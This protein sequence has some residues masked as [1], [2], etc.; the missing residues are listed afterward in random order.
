MTQK[1]IGVIYFPLPRAGQLSQGKSV[2]LESAL[3]WT[4]SPSGPAAKVPA[5]RSP[6]R[7]RRSQQWPMAGG[8]R[9]LCPAL[10][11]TQRAR[12]R[13]ASGGIFCRLC[14]EKR[15]SASTLQAAAWPGQ[16]LCSEGGLPRWGTVLV[17]RPPRNENVLLIYTQGVLG[18]QC[19]HAARC[20]RGVSGQLLW[21]VTVA[22]FREESSSP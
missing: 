8:C 7:Q 10:R 19:G 11:R 6:A 17:P 13:V 20:Q 18:L 1:R 3:R 22:A 15:C 16:A 4:R 14:A 21:A 2:A 5:R 12:R 9:S